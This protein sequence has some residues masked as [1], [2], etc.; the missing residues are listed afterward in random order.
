MSDS[1][2]PYDDDAAGLLPADVRIEIDAVVTA[3]AEAER[4]IAAGETVDLTAQQDQVG[5]LCDR[6]R[7]PPITERPA[8]RQA[9]LEALS[10]VANRFDRLARTV[11]AQLADLNGRLGRAAPDRTA[12]AYR[13]PGPRRT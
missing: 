1:G 13:R 12:S 5:A 4:R 10:Y 8:T 3:V 9:A 11:E 6:L 2:T 7:Q